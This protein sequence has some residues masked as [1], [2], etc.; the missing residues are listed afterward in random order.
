MINKDNLPFETHTI[1]ITLDDKKI[2]KL[3]EDFSKEEVKEIPMQTRENPYMV[4]HKS[5]FD[6]AKN[7]LLNKENPKISIEKAK[8][9]NKIGFLSDKELSSFIE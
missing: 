9:Y 1:Y 3:N 4:I 7:H 6:M 2:Y 8:L 5:Q